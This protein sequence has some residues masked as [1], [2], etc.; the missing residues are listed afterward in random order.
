MYHYMLRRYLDPAFG[1]WA[2][3]DIREKHIRAWRKQ[4]LDSRASQTSVAK[5][6]RL[7]KAIMNTAVDD[8]LI[9]RNPCRIKGAGL[10]RS[11]ERPILTMR[12]VFDLAGVVAPRYRT[13]VLLATFASLRWGELAALRRKDIDLDAGT[14]RIERSLTELV[15]GGYHFG[16]PKSAAGRRAVALPDIIVPDL[17]WHLARF[18]ADDDDALVF[19]SQAGMP[20]HHANFRRRYW[21]PALTKAGLAGVHFHHLRHTGNDFA[22]ATGATLREMMDRMGHS[23]T[24]AALIYMHGSEI[25]QRQIANTLSE[26]AQQGDH[27]PA[28]RPGIIGHAAGTEAEAPLGI[29]RE[30][31]GGPRWT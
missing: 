12:Q 4:Q 18:T 6:Y 25:R 8:G 14:V 31:A 2:L 21:L 24:R 30:M 20:L 22:A 15:G 10:D 3:A 7:F 28:L 26:L 1:K 17:T 9:R 16:Q 5:A 13:L 11:P 23:S 19:T 27:R 29:M